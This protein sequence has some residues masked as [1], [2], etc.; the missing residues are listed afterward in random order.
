RQIQPSSALVSKAQGCGNRLL[1]DHD[2]VPQFKW[3]RDPSERF[4]A[5]ANAPYQ[6]LTKTKSAA[7][8]PLIDINSLDLG[9]IHLLGTAGKPT[10]LVD[11][12]FVGDHD[13]RADTDEPR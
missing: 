6:H 5:S 4:P 13:L 2:C 1:P 8:D 12:P 9:Y 7:G 3:R 11:D 10:G